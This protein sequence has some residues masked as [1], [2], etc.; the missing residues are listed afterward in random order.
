MWSTVFMLSPQHCSSLWILFLAWMS[1]LI[2][3]NL[4]S[5][6][7]VWIVD[8]LEPLWENWQHC[9]LNLC[10]QETVL[11][12]VHVHGENEIWCWCVL[13]RHVR[14]GLW[15]DCW[16]HYCHIES[17]WDVW[18][19]YQFLQRGSNPHSFFS[20][21]KTSSLLSFTGRGCNYF[22]LPCILRDYSGAK[23]KNIATNTPS[24]I[25]AVGTIWVCKAK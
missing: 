8:T 25:Q 22:L 4:G 7:N 12:T 15:I 18:S 2:T 1:Q 10:R 21:F 19:A 9:L 14:E 16:W 6:A 11:E 3:S 17:L 23:W 24:G 5:P 20:F 13:C